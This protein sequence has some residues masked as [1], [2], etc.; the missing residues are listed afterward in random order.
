MLKAL[1]AIVALFV[2]AACERDPGP[3]GDRPPPADE[4]QHDN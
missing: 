4:Q 1:T 2:L 3:A